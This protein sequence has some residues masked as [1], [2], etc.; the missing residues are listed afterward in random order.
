MGF[1][2][3]MGG[4]FCMV[5]A[6]VVPAAA[7]ADTIQ[8]QASGT[9][10]GSCT[11]AVASGFPATSLGASGSAAAQATVNCNTG[12]VIKATSAKGAI[13]SPNQTSTGFTNTVPYTLAFSSPLDG[14]FTMSGGPCASAALVSGQSG[15]VLSPAGTGLSSGGRLATGKT[16]SLTLSWTLPAQKLVA[17]TYTDTITLTIAAAP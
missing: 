13:K 16:A 3:W 2:P 4:V 11:L 14:G 6:L 9:I 15:C 17:G 1:G 8:I 10:L 12:F 5:A 7:R